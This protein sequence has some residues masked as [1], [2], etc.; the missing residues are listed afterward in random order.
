MF[1]RLGPALLCALTFAI[2]AILPETA[3]ANLF[4]NSYISFELP[5]SW[6]CKPDGTDWICTN[7]YFSNAKQAMII[8]TA[9]AAGP[10]DTLAEYKNHLLIPKSIPDQ[11]G[12][13]ATSRVEEVKQRQING[14][15][16]VDGLQLGSEVT[17]YY[18]RYL[19]TIKDGV[20]ILV[21]FSAHKD[22]YTKYSGDFINAINSLQVVAAK[23]IL[24]GH[25]QQMIAPQGH[26]TIGAPITPEPWSSPNGVPPEPNGG[27]KD[28][29]SKLFAVALLLAAAGIYLWRKKK[30]KS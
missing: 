7:S 20:A 19:G 28:L 2:L 8:F 6:T 13:Y 3:F 17:Q 11:L 10:S 22:Y 27:H 23:D 4:R 5:P 9:K 30:K 16:W 14:Q 25:P 12:R 18:T 26:E 24:A 29:A 15:P 21:T 1:R